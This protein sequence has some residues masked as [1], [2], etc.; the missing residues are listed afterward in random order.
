[1]PMT[2]G[3]KNCVALVVGVGVFVVLFLL[4]VEMAP[5]KDLTLGNI[6]SLGLEVHNF[7]ETN[8]HLPSN[9]DQLKTDPR[10]RNDAWGRPI[11]YT[12]TSS[13]SYVLRS[14]GPHGKPGEDNMAY[15]FD[16]ADLSGTPAQ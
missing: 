2:S 10:F 13:T 15:A 6:S 11:T 7:Y 1:V 16:A 14:L 5:K 8:H 3:R 4:C 9:L 12:V